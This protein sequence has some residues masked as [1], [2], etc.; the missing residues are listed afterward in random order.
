MIIH[1]KRFEETPNDDGSF[2][3]GFKKN[4]RPIEYPLSMDMDDYAN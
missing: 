4:K 2:T 1:L 3:N